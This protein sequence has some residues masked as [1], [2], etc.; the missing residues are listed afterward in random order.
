[1]ERFRSIRILA[2]IALVV[3]LAALMNKP[4]SQAQS[5]QVDR[6]K[7]GEKLVQA[8]QEIAA[9]DHDPKALTP[10]SL[11][12]EM[13][14]LTPNG[15]EIYDEVRQFTPES[16]Y[17]QIDGRA[18]FFLAYD[19]IGMTFASFVKGTDIGQF[20]DL[21]IYDM[22]SATNAFGV[23]SVERSQGEPSLKLGRAGYRLDANYY[24]WK[25]HYYITI[26]ASHATD[27]FRHLGLELVRRVTKYLP[28]S[29]ESVWGLT[30]LP[31]KD[32]VSDSLQ[33]HKVDAMGLDFMRN[34]FIAAYRKN[35]HTVTAF[36][37]RHESAESAEA[38]IAKYVE[39]A[40]EYGRGVEHL[41]MG[42]LDLISCN[43]GESY[44]VIFQKERLMAGVW[45]VAQR[46]LAIQVAT[47]L[48]TQLPSE[49]WAS[50]IYLWEVSI[51]TEKK[52]IVR[53]IGGN[54]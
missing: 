23:F 21:S 34:T 18:E 37:S 48:Y 29:N 42:D 51:W 28:D 15:W 30:A 13:A 8:R 54:S 47:E 6:V 52:I 20:I 4:S 45:S 7:P 1:M 14:R 10:D 39:Y 3:A 53:W 40:K 16:L 31:Q 5:V 25:G 17:E 50:L 12:R 35:G 38:T 43:M 46:K 2:M 11:A 27:E 33:Y 26:I 36:V 9:N 49:N 41:N 22:G 24:I 44:D 32:R 19:V